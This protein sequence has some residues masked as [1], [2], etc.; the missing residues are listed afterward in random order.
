MRPNRS[1]PPCSVI[2][3]LIYP[4]PGGDGKFRPILPILPDLLRTA[5]TTIAAA[6]LD[7]RVNVAAAAQTGAGERRSQPGIVGAANATTLIDT[8]LNIEQLTD[9]RRLRPL[10]QRQ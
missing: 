10:M 4:D 8:V 7:S 5:G 6:A 3:V 9:V 2:P 1:V